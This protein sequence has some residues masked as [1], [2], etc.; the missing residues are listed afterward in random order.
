M[1]RPTEKIKYGEIQK[2]YE[3]CIKIGI[4]A[5][6]V[7]LFDGYCIIFPSGGEIIQHMGSCK[8]AFCVEP[9]IGSKCD[10]KPCLLDEAKRLVK[11]HKERL[12]RRADDA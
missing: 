12:N 9:C 1:K 3:Y 7:P 2:L 6:I 8:N 4:D 5:E 11:Y 10:Y